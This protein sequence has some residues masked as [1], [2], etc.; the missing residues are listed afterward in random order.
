MYSRCA[1]ISHAFNCFYF[2]SLL[3]ITF[4]PSNARKCKN[5]NDLRIPKRASGTHWQH[6]YP[7]LPTSHCCVVYLRP[8]SKWDLALMWRAGI[9]C[10]NTLLGDLQIVFG[11]FVK[12]HLVCL[13]QMGEF[14]ACSSVCQLAMKHTNCPKTSKNQV[15]TCHNQQR[16]DKLVTGAFSPHFPAHLGGFKWLVIESTRTHHRKSIWILDIATSP[17]QPILLKIVIKCLHATI[18]TKWHK[19]FGLFV[20]PSQQS[21]IPGPACNSAV[22]GRFTWQRID[23]LFS[24]WLHATPMIPWST[25]TNINLSTFAGHCLLLRYCK[26]AVKTELLQAMEVEALPI[27]SDLICCMLMYFANIVRKLQYKYLLVVRGYKGVPKRHPLSLL[28]AWAMIF[29]LPALKVLRASSIAL[30]QLHLALWESACRRC[31]SLRGCLRCI[32]KI[33]KALNRSWIAYQS[34]KTWVHQEIC[35]PTFCWHY[36]KLSQDLN[37]I[38]PKRHIRTPHRSFHA[39]ETLLLFGAILR[40]WPSAR[41]KNTQQPWMQA[42]LLFAEKWI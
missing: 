10:S 17:K 11:F 23:V 40:L 5:C 33:S 9:D 22:V 28:S 42:Q 37:L 7:Y 41:H 24:G 35:L 13:V 31:D 39:G 27:V 14:T 15:R 6:P 25:L 36:M 26:N 20:K 29:K 32:K 2:C 8:K 12:L 34:S 38:R 30:V 19:T 16:Y 4:F 3:N 21:I 1:C 18:G